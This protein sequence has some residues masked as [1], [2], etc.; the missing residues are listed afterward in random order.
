MD[1][2]DIYMK[3]VVFSMLKIILKFLFLGLVFFLKEEI[4]LVVIVSIFF[5]DWF[6]IVYNF[7]IVVLSLVCNS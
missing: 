7:I 3:L 5:L 2:F 4:K 1:L 6:I